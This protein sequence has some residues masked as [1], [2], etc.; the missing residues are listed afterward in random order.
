V[1]LCAHRDA[2]RLV[3]PRSIGCVLCQAR[4]DSWVQLRM[5]L[6][7]GQIGCS[8]RS[9][10]RHA[11]KHYEETDHPVIASCEPGEAWWWCYVDECYL[12]PAAG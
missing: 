12:W 2:I 9:E 3:H 4:G 7:C 6:T 10:N 5:C 11:L 8:D 1:T